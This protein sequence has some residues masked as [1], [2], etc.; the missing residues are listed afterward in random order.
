MVSGESMVLL[1]AVLLES[2]DRLV[3]F[4]YFLFFKSKNK[5]QYCFQKYLFLAI[6]KYNHQLTCR[7]AL[8]KPL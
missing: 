7:T 1:V 8:I 6:H 3:G 2:F 5:K 4:L